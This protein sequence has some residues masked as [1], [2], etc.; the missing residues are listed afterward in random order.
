MLGTNISFCAKFAPLGNQIKL[1]STHAKHLKGKRITKITKFLQL[2]SRRE[3][4][5][6]EAIFLKNFYFHILFVGKFG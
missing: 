6:I 3:P 5:K 2:G 4:K 1:I